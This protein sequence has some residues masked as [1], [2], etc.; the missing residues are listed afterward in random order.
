ML[1]ETAVTSIAAQLAEAEAAQ[2]QL[3]QLAGQYP[4]MTI[5]DGYAV[6]RAWLEIKLRAGRKVRGHKIGLTSRAMQRAVN[7]DEPDYGVLLDDMFL[8]DGV[9]IDRKRLI[10]PRVEAELAFVLS[11]KLHGPDCTIFDVLDATAYVV[12]ALEILDARIERVDAKTGRTRSVVETISD[13]AANCAV[14]CGGR[15]VRP[16]DIDMRLATALVFRNGAIEET[17][18]AAGV[19]NHRKRRCL[20]GKPSSSDGRGT[21]GRRDHS[22]RLLHPPD[23]RRRRRQ[24]PRR[25]RRSGVSHLPLRVR[26]QMSRRRS[27]YLDEFAHRNPIPV[28]C[29]IDGLIVSG[30]IYGLNSQTGRPAETLDE[31]CRLM[32]QHLRSILKASRA[33]PHDVIKLNVFLKDR[34]QRDALN[35]EWIA[36]YPDPGDRPVRQAM[37]AELDG[38]KLVQCDFVAR[39]P[40]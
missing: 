2:R 4:E 8:A 16:L 39:L 3:A 32:F 37:Q 21:R 28:A 17:G 36:M 15:P 9:A 14:V 13:N 11:S 38:G 24:F 26:T 34:S 22:V 25:F 19:M 1:D 40:V 6:Q 23:R 18:V 31:Q 27:I 10:E 30:I 20:A 35:R 5:E 29:E 12:P 33:T 7:I